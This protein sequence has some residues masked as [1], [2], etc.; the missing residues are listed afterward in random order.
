ML[1]LAQMRRC[2]DV[3]SARRSK[4]YSKVCDVIQPVLVR[5]KDNSFRK[6]NDVTH[7][8]NR[9]D[10]TLN[11]LAGSKW[12]ST[13]DLASG[14][15]VEVA[16]KDRHKT[17]FSTSVRI[18]PFGCSCHLGPVRLGISLYSDARSPSI[19]PTFSGLKLQPNSYNTKSSTWGT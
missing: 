15:Q 7:K 12:F 5:K 19:W 17:A 11:T 9:I 4:N 16:E 18:M 2:A 10:D 8:E 14:A 6:L 3:G 1:S 13:L